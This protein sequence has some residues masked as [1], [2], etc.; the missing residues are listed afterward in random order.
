[1]KHSTM[2]EM[3]ENRIATQLDLDTV[4]S[5][6]FACATRLGDKGLKDWSHYY[7]IE[8]LKEKL[9]SQNGYIFSING[10]DI[11]VVFLSKENSGYYSPADLEKFTGAEAIYIGT[12]AVKPEFQ[13]QGYASQIIDFCK[14]FAKQN[15][16]NYLRLDCNKKDGP[17]VGF[18]QKRGFTVVA[19]ME[20]EPEY[21][22]LEMK[23]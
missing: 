18:Y 22:L 10:N 11:G 1:M 17:L 15:K 14:N 13:H 9:N 2:S 16:I 6:V 3:I 5:I 20:K 21:V 4:S 7:T 19:S 8:K 23:I 12:L